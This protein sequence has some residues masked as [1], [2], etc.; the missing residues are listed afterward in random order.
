M[1]GYGAFGGSHLHAEV[2]TLRCPNHGYVFVTR[3]GV[4][5]AGPGNVPDVDNGSAQVPAPPP[6][7]GT[8]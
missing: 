6:L 3:E 1:E 2:T 7:N 8:E 4:P 5:G